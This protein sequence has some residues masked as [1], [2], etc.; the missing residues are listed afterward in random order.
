MNAGLQFRIAAAQGI[1][2]ALDQLFK[3][4]PA[5]SNK[6]A[7]LSNQTFKFWFEGPNIGIFLLPTDSNIAVLADYSGAVDCTVSGTPSDYAELFM[8]QDAASALINGG[9]SVT[10][11]SR[12]LMALQSVF[13]EV[14]LDWEYEL[15][16]WIGDVAAHQV[17][18]ASRHVQTIVKDG[19]DDLQQAT[20]AH[21]AQ[22]N[23][24][25]ATKNEIRQFCDDVDVLI[26]RLERFEAKLTKRERDA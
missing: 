6:L 9:I 26:S 16:Q 23:S 25:L 2:T 4:D 13:A 11:D 24:L 22:S 5:L 7:S 1:E 20:K 14:E 8:A 10:G 19:V 17:G 21:F 15:S 12:K 3:L 18:Q